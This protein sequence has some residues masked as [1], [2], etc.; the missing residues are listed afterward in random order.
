MENRTLNLGFV[1]WLADPCW[2]NDHTIMPSH[3]R[4]SRVNVRIVVIGLGNAGLKVVWHY[5]RRYPTKELKCN[6]VGLD[7]VSQVH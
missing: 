1:I 6:A 5:D 4:I 2:E 3:V 7:P